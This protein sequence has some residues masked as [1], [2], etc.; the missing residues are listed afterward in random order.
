M[1]DEVLAW[2]ED[3]TVHSKAGPGPGHAK[4]G[5]EG[6]VRIGLDGTLRGRGGQGARARASECLAFL[7]NDFREARKES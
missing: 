6:V 5:I 7:R 3:G 1:V 2:W 4:G